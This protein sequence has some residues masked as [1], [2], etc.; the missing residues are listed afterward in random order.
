MKYSELLKSTTP[1]PWPNDGES[2]D[3]PAFEHEPNYTL[4]A[5]S[6]NVLPQVL[7]MAIK[8]RDAACGEEQ[9]KQLARYIVAAIENVKP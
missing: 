8:L 9:C 5:H 1:F 2:D 4:A 6:V 3:A 7:E